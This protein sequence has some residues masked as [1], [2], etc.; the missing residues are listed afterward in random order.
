VYVYRDNRPPRF[1]RVRVPYKSELE[2]LVQLISQRADS[3]L[4]TRGLLKLDAETACHAA[5][6]CGKGASALT[7]Q[8]GGEPLKI[9]WHG[10]LCALVQE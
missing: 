5:S 7:V 4:E 6:Y 9:S 10:L 8:S 3:C 1:Q 2:D